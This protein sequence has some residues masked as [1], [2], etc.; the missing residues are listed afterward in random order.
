MKNV[1]WGLVVD[2]IVVGATGH[3]GGG[4]GGG[5]A[6]CEARS[7]SN[8]MSWSHC[9]EEAFFGRVLHPDTQIWPPG[10]MMHELYDVNP[11]ESLGM[12]RMV[13]QSIS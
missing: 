9:V 1:G 3:D 5:T 6:E 13:Y 2:E 7:G 8:V 4:A 10:A 11:A 12:R